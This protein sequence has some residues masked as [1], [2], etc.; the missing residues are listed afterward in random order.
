MGSFTS[1]ASCPP[2]IQPEQQSVAASQS[3]HNVRAQAPG[4]SQQSGRGVPGGQS[5]V[6]MG[7]SYGNFRG[8]P[9]GSPTQLMLLP[10]GEWNGLSFDYTVEMN[11]EYQTEAAWPNSWE[12]SG[13]IGGTASHYSVMESSQ[14]DS[15]TAHIL[16]WCWSCEQEIITQDAHA[17]C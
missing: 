11:Y 10:T 7:S 3:F 4:N 8:W 9:K 2:S 1:N 16:T 6:G 13:I 5:S 12:T 17:W 15:N 14:V